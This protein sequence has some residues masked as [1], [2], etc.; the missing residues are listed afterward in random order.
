MLGYDS[1]ISTSFKS[2]VEIMSKSDEEKKAYRTEILFNIG[3]KIFKFAIYNLLEALFND[4]LNPEL[5]VQPKEYQKEQFE[6]FKQIINIIPYSD[7]IKLINGYTELDK[8]E[9]GDT[10]LNIL[11]KRLGLL[12]RE[13]VTI[14][15]LREVFITIAEDYP[16][17]LNVSMIN[18]T[19]LP[20][21]VAP[22]DPDKDGNKKNIS[23]IF[24]V[25]LVISIIHLIRLLNRNSKLEIKLKTKKF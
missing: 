16:H 6:N 24:T 10:V 9:I 22:N 13:V 25:K 7:L 12:D 11:E 1:V 19:Q 20:M 17:K 5:N 18:V 8:L 15:G 2:L 3:N 14:D 23:L 21:L 4:M